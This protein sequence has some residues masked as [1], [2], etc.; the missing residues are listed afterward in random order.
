EHAARSGSDPGVGGQCCLLG[1]LTDKHHHKTCCERGPTSCLTRTIASVIPP[2]MPGLVLRRHLDHADPR[3][4]ALTARLLAR[5][6][7][8]GAAAERAGAPP[9]RG[10]FRPIGGVRRVRLGSRAAAG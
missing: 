3:G 6:A 5:W 7:V 2:P 4:P 1:A 10:G 9:L 8:W